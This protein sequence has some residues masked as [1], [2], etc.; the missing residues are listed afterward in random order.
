MTALVLDTG[1]LVALER[2]DSDPDDIRTLAA[3]LGTPVT[4]VRV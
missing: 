3:A 4:I 2:V 1:A